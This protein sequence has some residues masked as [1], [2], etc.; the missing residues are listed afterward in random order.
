MQVHVTPALLV[1]PP[2]ANPGLH[3]LTLLPQLQTKLSSSSSS[4]TCLLSNLGVDKLRCTC[5]MPMFAGVSVP[6][7]LEAAHCSDDL[8]I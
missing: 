6:L 2:C 4:C 3:T 8:K 5:S 1:A 7:E